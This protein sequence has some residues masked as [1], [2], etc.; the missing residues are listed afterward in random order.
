MPGILR[1]VSMFFSIE[2]GKSKKTVPV[3]LIFVGMLFSIFKKLDNQKICATYF[4]IRKYAFLTF[5]EGISKK[6]GLGFLGFM[7][8]PFF[9]YFKRVEAKNSVS[10]FRFISTFF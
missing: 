1:F 8:M 3:I 5:E 7:S 10:I 4:K 6:T 9:K 2:K